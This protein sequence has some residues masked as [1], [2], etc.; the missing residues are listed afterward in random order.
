MSVLACNRAGCENIM[1]EIYSP[2]FGYICRDCYG[3]LV[4]ILENAGEGANYY[5]LTE[6]FMD[7]EKHTAADSAQEFLDREFERGE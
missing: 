1:C 6:A 3:E 4:N 7:T 5:E 2:D